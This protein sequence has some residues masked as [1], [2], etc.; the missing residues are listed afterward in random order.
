MNT[1]VQYTV[2]HA[3]QFKHDN[4]VGKIADVYDVYQK[5]TKSDKKDSGES[6]ASADIDKVVAQCEGLDTEAQSFQEETENALNAWTAREADFDAM[7]DKV[8][9][10]DDWGHEKA[11][12]IR[13]AADTI[14][15]QV[16]E[17]KWED[18]LQNLEQ[19]ESQFVPVYEDYLQQKAAKE[20]F[21]PQWESLQP[22]LDTVSAADSYESLAPMRQDAQAVQA[23]MEAAVEKRDYVQALQVLQD[24][25]PRVD[26]YEQIVAEL[27]RQ[28]ET[29]EQERQALDPKLADAAS[30]D[31]ESLTELDQDI[32]DL[33]TKTDAAATA[34][35]LKKPQR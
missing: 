6:P 5:V 35:Q 16:N 2:V 4:L 10:L 31:Y 13:Q 11:P 27:D 18:A 23:E 34:D 14:E 32:G 7:G 15:A 33:T 12:S 25:S 28:R 3:E 19:L 22:R 26:E 29:Y 17:R 30:S 20:Q 9:E 24:L 1:V 8:R 21:D